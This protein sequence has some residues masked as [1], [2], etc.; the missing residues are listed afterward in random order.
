MNLAFD[1]LRTD[2]GAAIVDGEDPLQLD[3][4]CVAI[5][6]DHRGQLGLNDRRVFPP[7]PCLLEQKAAEVPE[8]ESIGRFLS[9]SVK[10][11]RALVMGAARRALTAQV[12]ALLSAPRRLERRR[13]GGRAGR[14]TAASDTG[15]ACPVATREGGARARRLGSVAPAFGSAGR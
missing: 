11:T 1:Q 3:L 10:V 5:N 15:A 12:P 13:A 8:L 9:D 4:A 14:D 6:L 2:D 7:P